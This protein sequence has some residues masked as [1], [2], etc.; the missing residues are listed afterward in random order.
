MQPFVAAATASNDSQA[1]ASSFMQYCTTNMTSNVLACKPVADAITYSLNG[2]LAKRAG[3]LCSRLQQCMDDLLLPTA[4][5]NLTGSTASGTLNLCSTQG[6]GVPAP[7]TPPGELCSCRVHTMCFMQ[8]LAE[9][10]LRKPRCMVPCMRKAV[11]N[12]T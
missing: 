7:V 6:V 11:S 4:R 3:A 9:E 5:C 10:C 1:L 2:V 8:R 12:S